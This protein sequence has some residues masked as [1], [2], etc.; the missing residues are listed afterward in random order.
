MLGQGHP[1]ERKIKRTPTV[2]SSGSPISAHFSKRVVPFS[3]ITQRA[4]YESRPCTSPASCHSLGSKGRWIYH[5]HSSPT[6]ALLR[7]PDCSQKPEGQFP[8]REV[9]CELAIYFQRRGASDALTI[10]PMSNYCPKD[11]SIVFFPSTYLGCAAQNEVVD[12]LNRHSKSIR[13]CCQRS[14]SPRRSIDEQY[15]LPTQ[16]QPPSTWYFHSLTSISDPETSAGS[17]LSY[18]P[19]ISKRS[20]D[21]QRRISYSL[22][23]NFLRQVFSRIQYFLNPD[24]SAG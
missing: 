18:R 24:T 2:H 21:E 9:R 10:P 22:V 16:S 17:K 8:T 11:R 20:I 1:A 14:L 5:C 19:P 12:M 6:W 23:P 4:R 3:S 7:H 13:V 15:N